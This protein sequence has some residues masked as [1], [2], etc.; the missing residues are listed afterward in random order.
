ML[1]RTESDGESESYQICVSNLPQSKLSNI[2]TEFNNTMIVYITIGLYL[3]KVEA[4]N[5]ITSSDLSRKAFLAS[6][7]N[8]FEKLPEEFEMFNERKNLLKT[9]R[10][11]SLH[12][13]LIISAH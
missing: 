7:L 5:E 8:S 9:Q 11:F 1:S 10:K 12:G 3:C 6:L 2:E 13:M 4:P